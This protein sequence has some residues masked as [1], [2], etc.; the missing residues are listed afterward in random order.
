MKLVMPHWLRSFC[1]LALLAAPGCAP[2]VSQVPLGVGPQ[3]VAESSAAPT[4]PASK[5]HA[6]PQ[7]PASAKV[8]EASEPSEDEPAADSDDAVTTESAKEGTS[9]ATPSS[10]ATATTFS[11]MYAGTDIATFR[12][13]GRPD[14]R[15]EDDKAKIRV[16]VD[17]D[18]AISIVIINSDTGE[19]LCQLS[20]SIAG[21]VATVTGSE[22]CF[23]NPDD[24]SVS[25]MITEGRATL[26]D[27]ELK[28]TAE[29]TMSVSLPDQ[30][31]SGT[32]SYTFKG[33][34]Q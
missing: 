2:R 6:P 26:K 10:A 14:Q 17:G 24:D 28:V 1:V 13:D 29:G 25:A 8:A 9:S 23:T 30:S 16:E 18:D 12:F 5:P 3:A 21:K 20:A 15:Q 32:L 27:D 34:R 7:R 11:G 19:D 33:K 4:T 22:P 31:L